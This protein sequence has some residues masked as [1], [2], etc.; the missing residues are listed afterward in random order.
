M[1]RLEEELDRVAA[2]SD[3]SG[4][5]RVDHEQ[6]VEVLR[7]YGL[8]DRRYGIP[9]EIDTRFA[10]ASGTKDL[11]RSPLSASSKVET[12]SWTLG[13]ARCS[14]MTCRS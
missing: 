3:F 7:A 9:N 10:I 5:V 2:E 13:R 8:D 1:S 11:P 4:V 12:S 14:A 6:R